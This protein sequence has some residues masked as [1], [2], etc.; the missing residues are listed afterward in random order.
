MRSFK[1]DVSTVI[2]KTVGLNGKTPRRLMP[3]AARVFQRMKRVLLD[4]PVAMLEFFARNAVAQFVTAQLLF[5]ADRRD[6]QGYI[7]LFTE[8][9]RLLKTWRFVMQELH[10]RGQ[11][12]GFLTQALLFFDWI[13]A[14]NL[15]V[16]QHTDRVALDRIQQLGEQRVGLALVLLL[17]VLLRITTQMDAVTQVI[18]GRQVVFP[19]VVEHAQYDLLLE[20]AQRFGT[21]LLFFF[22]VRQQQLAEQLLAQGLFVQVIVFVEPLL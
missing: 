2:R 17:R 14:A 5:V 1:N 22:V 16:R 9:F 19:Q 7:D 4:L 18:H 20:G 11:C 13:F 12:F 6:S 21:G 15:N 8:Q 10:A 3:V